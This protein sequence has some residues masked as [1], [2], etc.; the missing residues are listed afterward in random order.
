MKPDEP[1]GA[2]LDSKAWGLYRLGRYEEALET[3][4]LIKEERFQDDDEYLEHLGSIQA[5]LGKK[6]EATK[7]FRHLLKVS[8]KHPAALEFLKGKKK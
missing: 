5:A 3:I 2:V 7:T 8:P 4:L 1:K 6:A